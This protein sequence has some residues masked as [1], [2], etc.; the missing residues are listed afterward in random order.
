M[1]YPY[2]LNSLAIVL[3]L[4]SAPSGSAAPNGPR[5]VLVELF[6]SEGCSSCPPADG[7]LRN[8]D[9]QQPVPGAQIIVLE[10]HVD[11]WDGDG[12]KDPFSSHEFTMRQTEY[13]QRLH[14]AEPYTPQMV[15][16]GSFEF[17]GNDPN[18]ATQAFKKA[19]ATPVVAIRIS[20]A[21]LT[22]GTLH[23]R[24]EA[25]PAEVKANVWVA[26]AV[27]HA[28]SQVLRGE[29]GGRHLEHVAVV[30]KLSQ[31]GKLDKQTGFS[32]DVTFKSVNQPTRVVAFLQEPGQGKVIGAAMVQVHP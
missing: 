21:G 28:E 2:G 19:L 12:W 11:Y 18:R 5:P 22:D 13:A 3:L 25:D 14:V 9:G 10:E 29:N 15:V 20:S 4:A 26:L 24:I 7:F 1:T 17:V 32:K 16:D 6:T 30:R 31:I 23:A 8:L 27:D